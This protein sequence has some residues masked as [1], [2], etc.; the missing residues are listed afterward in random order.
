[1]AI[2]TQNFENEQRFSNRA[3]SFFKRY[4]IGEILRKSNAYKHGGI[5]VV[6]VVMYL[7]L[8]VFRNRTLNMDMESGRKGCNFC[9]DTVYRLKNSFYINW[10]RFTTLLSARIIK[11]SIQP[12]TSE[13]RR[14]A[15]I[16]DDTIFERGRSKQVELLAW[17]FDHARHKT[18]RG[19]QLLTLSWSDGVT[20]IPVNF[21][22]SSSAKAESRINEA[23]SVPQNSAAAHRRQLAKM[24]KTDVVPLLLKDA[25]DAGISAKYVL[26]DS[27]FCIPKVIH[28]LKSMNLHTVAMVKKG[29][30]KY[31]LCGKLLNCK[32]LFAAY[33]KRPGR[34]KY[35][36]SVVVMLPYQPEK[37]NGEEKQP[38]EILIPVKLVFVRNRNKRNE[39]LLLLSTDLSLSEEE[40]IQLY[41][42]RWGIE[43]FFKTCK[44]VLKLTGECHSISYDAMCAH[45]AI[46]FVR[47]MLLALEARKEQDPRTAGPIFCLVSDEIAD[48]SFQQAFEFLQQIWKNLLRELK[49][50]EQ[51]ISALFD[52]LSA[53]LPVDIAALLGLRG[54]MRACN[55][56]FV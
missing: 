20:Q 45:C 17:K 10:Q 55:T 3:N 32:E 54:H 24:K 8:L 11:D 35:L 41:G 37:Q 48:I 12:L 7:F 6:T 21:C 47:Y 53:N 44:S 5:A 28:Q 1:M 50:P 36:L 22:L 52:E 56:H 4:Q 15:F 30:Q 42:K 33:R 31:Q 25:I 26:F 9:R 13:E 38:E 29:Q 16:I 51:Q 14:D 34:S 2:I 43:V 23:Q 39:Y 19:F 49:L 40:I 46:V 18:V 27:W